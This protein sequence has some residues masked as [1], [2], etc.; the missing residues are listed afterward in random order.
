MRCTV[1]V[2]NLYSTEPIISGNAQCAA[3]KVK[4]IEMILV[5]VSYGSRLQSKK[6]RWDSK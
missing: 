3:K 4:Y 2:I 1:T 6:L 5:L